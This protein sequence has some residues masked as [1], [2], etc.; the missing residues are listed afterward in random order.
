MAVRFATLARATRSRVRRVELHVTPCIVAHPPDELF[1]DVLVVPA[2]EFLVGT[3]LPYFPIGGPVPEPLPPGVTNSVWGGMEAGHGMM[4]SV[5]V[6][7]GAVTEF[8]GHELVQALKGVP[9]VDTTESHDGEPR[10]GHLPPRRC[11]IG[12]AVYTIAAGSLKYNFG[13]L[14]HTVPPF[15]SDHNWDELLASCYQS[16]LDIAIRKQRGKQGAR[17]EG[18]CDVQGSHAICGGDVGNGN[19]GDAYGRGTRE[20]VRNYDDRG[21]DDDASFSVAVPLLGAG[22]RGAPTDEAAAV[23][24]NAISR[25]ASSSGTIEAPCKQSEPSA[26]REEATTSGVVLRFGVLDNEVAGLIEASFRASGWRVLESD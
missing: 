13:S 10:N 25:W 20:S 18:S 21:Q 2:N 8:G 7:D 11:R 16:S 1:H 5:Q 17:G 24:A 6:V 22:A 19:S 9:I 26:S 15:R 3:S 12:N 23:A 14:V 4:Y